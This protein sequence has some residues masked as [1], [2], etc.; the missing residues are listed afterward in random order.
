MTHRVLIA[1]DEVLIAMQAED[2]LLEHG[3]DVC[4]VVGTASDALA[5]ARQMR[6]DVCIMDIRL[7]DGNSLSTAATIL[8]ELAI[9]VVLAS[10][11]VGPSSAAATG[12]THWLAKP[13]TPA[14][15]L[16]AVRR[17]VA[18]RASAAPTA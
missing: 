1:E 12:T 9:P 2:T 3:Y 16:A 17:A 6:P 7:R 15:L 14:N 8:G 13:Y 11:N 5:R 10:G 4:A 18:A